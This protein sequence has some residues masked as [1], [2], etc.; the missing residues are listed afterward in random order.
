MLKC[1]STTA[2]LQ[3]LFILSFCWCRAMCIIVQF[4]STH[5]KSICKSGMKYLD[6]T[7]FTYFMPYRFFGEKRSAG[8]ERHTPW[9]L[10]INSFSSGLVLYIISQWVTSK[11]A[12]KLIISNLRSITVDSSIPI[13][14]LF[15]FMM[16]FDCFQVSGFFLF[17]SALLLLLNVRM[18]AIKNISICWH[19]KFRFRAIFFWFLSAAGW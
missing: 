19:F 11:R 4:E 16:N 10:A 12:T 1:V 5:S 7:S 6:C 3:T 8:W 9:Q 13:Q 15:I 18:Y 2:L 14:Y 17:F